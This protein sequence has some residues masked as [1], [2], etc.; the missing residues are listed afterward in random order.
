MINYSEREVIGI[1]GNLFIDK[2]PEKF[3]PEGVVLLI[4][5]TCYA[6]WMVCDR[7]YPDNITKDDT[8]LYNIDTY[9]IF[10]ISILQELV[11]YTPE[12]YKALEK[13]RK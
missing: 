10:D 1:E 7:S 13:Y 4:K 9:R 5:G 8:L 12:P 2:F 6:D 11:P 3:D